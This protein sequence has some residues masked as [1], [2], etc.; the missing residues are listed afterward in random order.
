MLIN[1]NEYTDFSKKI[2]VIRNKL[3]NKKFLRIKEYQYISSARKKNKDQSNYN[4]T[5]YNNKGTYINN[6]NIVK[7][8][9][10]L[11]TKSYSDMQLLNSSNENFPKIS[12][13]KSSLQKNVQFNSIGKT[14]L[15]NMSTKKEFNSRKINNYPKFNNLILSDKTTKILNIETINNKTK[16]DYLPYPYIRLQKK[17]KRFYSMSKESKEIAERSSFL[18]SKKYEISQNNIKKKTNTSQLFYSIQGNKKF[19]SINRLNKIKK[20]NEK[21][22]IKNEIEKEIE[23]EKIIDKIKDKDKDKEDKSI[24][25]DILLSEYSFNIK[26]KNAQISHKKNLFR[27]SQ[28]NSNNFSTLT[29]LKNKRG[30]NFFHKFGRNK[31]VSGYKISLNKYLEN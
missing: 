14:S 6:F 26:G 1:L 16:L 3:S 12:I 27:N 10:I 19:I 31:E 29:L 23:K 9:P 24:N 21:K 15:T 20:I 8:K 5:M 7:P 18:F 17:F 30:G 13:N 28:T 11:F 2:D 25:T 4:Q 22:E